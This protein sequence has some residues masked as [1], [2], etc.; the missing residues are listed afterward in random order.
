MTLV[1]L[2]S[3]DKRGRSTSVHLRDGESTACGLP[4]SDATE[5]GRSGRVGM[6][7]RCLRVQSIRGTLTDAWKANK[8]VNRMALLRELVDL[9]AKRD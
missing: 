2:P 1:R 5:V 4:V 8:P 6:C 3:V 7:S 9:R